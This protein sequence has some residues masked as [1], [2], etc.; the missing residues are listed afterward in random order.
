MKPVVWGTT[1]GQAGGFALAGRRTD[2]PANLQWPLPSGQAADHA[3]T[4]VGIR[5]SQILNQVIK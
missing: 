2:Q 1:Q 4:F 3:R 5:L